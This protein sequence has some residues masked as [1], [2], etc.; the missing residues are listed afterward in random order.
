MSC[1]VLVDTWHRG[2]DVR[3]MFIVGRRHLRPNKRRGTN[4]LSTSRR[5]HARQPPK[6]DRRH[7]QHGAPRCVERAPSQRRGRRQDGRSADQ[8]GCDAAEQLT[9]HYDYNRL[10]ITQFCHL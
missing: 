3:V 6:R 2:N 4:R 5:R 10:K 9:P 1:P 8:T 7:C